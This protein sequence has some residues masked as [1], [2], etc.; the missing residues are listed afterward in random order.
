VEDEGNNVELDELI[1]FPT[2]VQ[3][4]NCSITCFMQ[5]NLLFTLT[6]TKTAPELPLKL[7]TLHFNPNAKGTPLVPL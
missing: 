3:A 2:T 7:W 1:A 6:N 5:N 4:S